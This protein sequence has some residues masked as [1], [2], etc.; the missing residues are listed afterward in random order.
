MPQVGVVVCNGSS[1]RRSMSIY[2]LVDSGGW[3]LYAQ[4]EGERVV[5]VNSKCGW[6]RRRVVKE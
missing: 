4:Q 1:N 5:S 2:G 6:S 3:R